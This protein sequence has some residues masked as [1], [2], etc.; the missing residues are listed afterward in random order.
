MGHVLKRCA[1]I[2]AA[3]LAFAPA[4]KADVITGLFNTG[5]DSLGVPL[6][7]SQIDQ[8]WTLNGGA[9]YTSSSTGWPIGG[10]WVAD[11]SIS[12]WVTPTTNAANSL[13][14]ASN[15]F[16][17]YNLT[18]SLAGNELPSTARFS[19]QFAA[20]DLVTLITLNGNSIYS[21]SFNPS[22]PSFAGGWTSFGALSGF[23]S[24]E[25]ILSIT[26]ENIA[27]AQSNPTGLD[28]QFT[29]SFVAPIPEPSTWLMMIAGF[30]ALGAVAFRRRASSVAA[31]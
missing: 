31:A 8:H 16:Y 26:V 22:D 17:T 9:A 24:G 4:A 6:I 1:V 12:R 20:D 28:V 29:G 13:D 30:V 27:L 11:S 23:T 21:H 2:T 7:G 10:P 18:F 19:G 5:V 15:G 25:N 14:L 3:A